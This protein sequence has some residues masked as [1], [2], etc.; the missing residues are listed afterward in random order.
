MVLRA[1][2][3]SGFV[4][5]RYYDQYRWNGTGPAPRPGDARYPTAA[6]RSTRGGLSP[7]STDA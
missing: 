1:E 6:A 2:A 3:D 7:P 5:Y 4:T